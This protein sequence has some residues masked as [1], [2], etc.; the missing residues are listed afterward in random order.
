M[1]IKDRV[2]SHEEQPPKVFER[3][4]EFLIE[5]VAVETLIAAGFNYDETSASWG[6]DAG[7][8]RAHISDGRIDDPENSR[9]NIVIIERLRRRGAIKWTEFFFGTISGTPIGKRVEESEID[10]YVTQMEAIVSLECQVN[11]ADLGD[12]LDP[13]VSHYEQITY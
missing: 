6:D 5:H 7:W 8:C 11:G 12:L 2:V 4:N 13:Y 9:P 3:H 10:E 1:A